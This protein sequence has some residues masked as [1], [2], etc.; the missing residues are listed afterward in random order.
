MGSPPTVK[1][2]EG[3]RIIALVPNTTINHHLAGCWLSAT[4][5][6][7]PKIQNNHQYLVYL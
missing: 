4:V 7:A 3:T 5:G 2:F 1:Y 6:V